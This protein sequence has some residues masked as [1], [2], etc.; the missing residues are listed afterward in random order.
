[1]DQGKLIFWAII[2]FVALF[3]L[4]EH[5]NPEGATRTIASI[6]AIGVIIWILFNIWGG[7][8]AA[9]SRGTLLYLLATWF[10]GILGAS[11]FFTE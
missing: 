3:A 1:M 11:Y 7:I 8:S 9:N 2:G 6:V 10:F 4:L 5:I